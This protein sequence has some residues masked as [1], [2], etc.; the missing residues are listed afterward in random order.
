MA[1]K[2]KKTS[3]ASTVACQQEEAIWTLSRQLSDPIDSRKG[4]EET[5]H[6]V[7]IPERIA[8]FARDSRAPLLARRPQRQADDFVLH[9][10]LKGAGQ[11]CLDEQ[12]YRLEE[13]QAL[14]IFPFQFRHFISVQ[15]SSI[16]WLLISFDLSRGDSLEFRR[17]QPWRLTPELMQILHRLLEALSS[18]NSTHT[19]SGTEA[20]LL[21]AQ[22]LY[23]SS[24]QEIKLPSSSPTTFAEA[25]KW[26]E[27]IN[28]FLNRHLDQPFTLEDMARGIGCSERYLRHQFKERFKISLGHYVTR[29]R[30]KKA[31]SLL[32]EDSLNISGVAQACGYSSLYAFGR[33][34]R[35]AMGCT[36]R[37]Y[38]LRVN[39]GNTGR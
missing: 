35:A 23:Q 36:P 22:L 7:C 27:R 10:I 30:L 21:L 5:A 25:Q 13:G 29:R 37:D 28:G 39:K 11:V 38:R 19:R 24:T 14:L 15:E 6:H 2:L 20:Q 1:K 8:V 17:N 16:H 18:K 32:H 12:I 3:A 4:R 33:A 26:L 31:A 34:F 9:V